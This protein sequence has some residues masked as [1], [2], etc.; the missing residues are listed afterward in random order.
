MRQYNLKM[1]AIF[2]ILL[3]PWAFISCSH[4]NSDTE[5]G[6]DDL[7]KDGIEVTYAVGETSLDS[8]FTRSGAVKPEVE[9]Q[10]F[11]GM[12]VETSI[13]DESNDEQTRATVYNTVNLNGKT[14]YALVFDPN[15]NKTIADEQILTISNNKLTVKGKVGCK[16][17]FYIGNRTYS[18]V[19][20]D[21]S[22]ITVSERNSSDAMQCISDPITGI[23][24]ELG[25]LS[26][27][28]VFTKIRVTMKTSNGK[29]VNAF[30]LTTKEGLGYQS[31][32]VKIADRSYTTSGTQGTKTFTVSN[33]TEAVA[34]ADY[35]LIIA[36]ATGAQ[37]DLSLVFA[38]NGAG[39]TIDGAM[40]YLTDVNN[41]LTLKSRTFLPGHRYSI[42]I[43][44]K[45]SNTEAYL[46]TGFNS[47]K[48]F[49][50][51]DAYERFGVGDSLTWSAG[52]S[53]FH[54]FASADNDK[55]IATQSCKNC[56]SLEEVKMYLGAGVFLDNGFTGANQQ[57]Y[58][59]VD[60]YLK[61]KITYHTGVWLLKKQY[62]TGFSDGTA[63]KAT[64][65]NTKGRPSAE[66]IDKYFFLPLYGF[67][68]MTNFS[69]YRTP[70][71]SAGSTGYFQ[72]KTSRFC[73]NSTSARLHV[74]RINESQADITTLNWTSR[75][76]CATNIWTAD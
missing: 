11:M 40:N 35:Q 69:Y 44:V 29:I 19:G 28:H 37:N 66:D 2:A 62:I 46:N 10:T 68:D 15:T 5:G 70:H 67:Y 16:V 26:F 39:A 8:I 50:Q 1:T 14:V 6:T 22:S 38:K 47:D 48:N 52:N 24:S 55:D 32:L 13:T 31:A 12:D 43:T 20:T 60:T 61:T 17:L 75:N 18:S 72:T 9:Q 73:Y 65:S 51:W 21:I 76:V 54:L 41:T 59:I 58:T 64:S 27:K 57:S 4:D 25:T 3:F 33:N 56:P 63:T 34:A 23:N 45:P 53:G 71:L 7:L 36:N 30:K 42:N 74:L 49:Y